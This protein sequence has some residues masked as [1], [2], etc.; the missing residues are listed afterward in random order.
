MLFDLAHSLYV[1]I[2]TVITIVILILATIYL[3]EQKQKDVFLKFFAIIT[4]V[5]HYSGLW[6][7]FLSTGTAEAGSALLFAVYPCHVCMWLLVASAFIKNRKTIGYRFVTEFTF[8]LGIVGGVLGIALN[9]NYM[10]N[11]TL[12]DWS[13]LQGLLSHSTLIIGCVWLL[14]GKY[15]KIRVFN[16]ISILLGMSLLLIDGVFVNTL[17]EYCKIGSVNSMYL[18]EP[19][20]ASMP[21]FNTAFMGILAIV[22]GFLITAI[23]EQIALPKEDRWYSHLAYWYNKK[24]KKKTKT[25]KEEE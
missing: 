18:L 3:K 4:V 12:A 8:Y 1:V 7:D 9:F 14:C 22:V 24:Y 10:G 17:F 11:P 6:V 2:S 19:P 13:V 5:L 16:T 21:W 15:I 25:E 20:V 23:Y